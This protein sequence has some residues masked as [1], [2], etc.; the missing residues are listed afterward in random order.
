LRKAQRQQA[1]QAPWGGQACQAPADLVAQTKGARADLQHL[2]LPDRRAQRQGRRGVAVPRKGLGV[3]AGGLLAYPGQGGRGVERRHAHQCLRRKGA[4]RGQFLALVTPAGRQWREVAGR[5]IQAAQ[6]RL[7][8]KRRHYRGRVI[9]VHA[10][11]MPKFGGWVS[12]CLPTMDKGTLR[13]P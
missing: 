8:A 13:C 5:R 2:F 7:H 10:R 12:A 6:A 9:E 4:Q 11:M 3:L 1:C